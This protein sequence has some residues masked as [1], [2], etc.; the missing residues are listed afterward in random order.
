MPLV[1]GGFEHALNNIV[2]LVLGAVAVGYFY[3]SIAA[4]VHVQIV[5]LGGLMV[6]LFARPSTHIGASGWVYGLMA[7]LMVSG[8][9]RREPRAAAVAAVTVLLNAGF[10][11]GMLPVQAGI[12]FEAHA[13]SAIVGAVLAVAYRNRDR[14]EQH[15]DWQN[16]PD[17][18]D[19]TGAWDYRRQL[20]VP[21]PSDAAATN[22]QPKDE[23]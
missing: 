13:Y 16:A 17:N 21:D 10:V 4:A 12:S 6:W 8:F 2:S 19:E 14:H 11:W 9:V 20:R 18:A 15:Y 7:F 1:H 3:P 23:A 5:L 22:D